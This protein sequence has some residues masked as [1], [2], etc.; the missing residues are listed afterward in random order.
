MIINYILLFPELVNNNILSGKFLKL[1]LKKNLNKL[2][3][4]LIINK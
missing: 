3:F 2:L 1:L 4:Y